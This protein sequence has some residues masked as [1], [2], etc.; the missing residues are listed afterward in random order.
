MS[1]FLIADSEV[2]KDNPE[3]DL[4]NLLKIISDN[5][6]KK[7]KSGIIS[8][9][10]PK[11]FLNCLRKNF[12][13]YKEKESPE[14]DS[15]LKD[16]FLMYY[17]EVK[18]SNKDRFIYLTNSNNLIETNKLLKEESKKD[19]KPLTLELYF[20]KDKVSKELIQSVDKFIPLE[21]IEKTN[22]LEFSEKEDLP[23]VDLS[24][25]PEF[26]DFPEVDNNSTGSNVIQ[27]I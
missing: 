11:D 1:I 20:W 12:I 25:I 13:I 2:I 3:L 21:S 7:F 15:F 27:G 16:I 19:G 5:K 8:G 10:F 9:T 18:R 6:M 26:E 17:L 23:E 4:I 22:P 14:E 24:N